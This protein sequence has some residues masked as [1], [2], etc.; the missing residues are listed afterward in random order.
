LI[1]FL[2][3]LTVFCVYVKI[4]F[5]SGVVS[6]TPF[7][8]WG[9]SFWKGNIHVPGIL[10]TPSNSNTWECMGVR[11]DVGASF[12]DRPQ[13][14]IHVCSYA[15]SYCQVRHINPSELRDIPPSHEGLLQHQTELQLEQ[16]L[17][18]SLRSLPTLA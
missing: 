3:K 2:G 12:S 13:R 1:F 17:M 16:I 7:V 8:I 10:D 6:R 14:L 5:F 4:S 18:D 15:S 9:V 11:E